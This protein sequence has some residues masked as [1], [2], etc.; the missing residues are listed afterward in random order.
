MHGEVRRDDRYPG[1]LFRFS[2]SYELSQCK[3]AVLTAYR[4]AF[5]FSPMAADH[6]GPAALAA[7]G[8]AG[9]LINLE[10]MAFTALIRKVDGRQCDPEL[11]QFFHL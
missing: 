7:L 5:A 3:Y 4:T 11:F 1:F 6:L 8:K 2:T 10:P 9:V